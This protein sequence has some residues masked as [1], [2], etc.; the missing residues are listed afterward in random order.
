MK[1]VMLLIYSC[2]L[3]L[4]S[5]IGSAQ[6]I[7]DGQQIK[8]GPGILYDKTYSELVPG[9]VLSYRLRVDYKVVN[10][11]GVTIPAVYSITI[12]DRD[13][14]GNSRISVEMRSAGELISVDTIFLTKSK[15][16]KIV[17][18]RLAFVIPKY[19]ATLDVYGRVLFTTEQ[20]EELSNEPAVKGNTPT[21]ITDSEAMGQVL[22]TIPTEY[23]LLAPY[24]RGS[25]S[26]LIGKPYVDTIL[27]TSSIQKIGQTIGT[28][29]NDHPLENLDTIIRAVTIDSISGIDDEEIAYM[30]VRME[31]H[32]VYGVHTIATSVM[33]RYVHKGYMKS[34]VT[35]N[36]REG[37]AGN[38]P[39][40]VATSILDSS[41]VRK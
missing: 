17:G 20:H 10:G 24:L 27:I 14:A 32:P 23:A 34:F 36:R 18:V 7:D 33:E 9:R 3:V 38:T 12:L 21:R 41:T 28:E 1:N 6:D 15:D 39:E 16:M 13:D 5:T 26:L 19:E 25:N 4:L 30:S 37:S 29:T 11:R 2:F 8:V 40:Y 31:R 35:T 22:S